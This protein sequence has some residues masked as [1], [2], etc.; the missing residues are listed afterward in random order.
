M[1]FSETISHLAGRILV[2][3]S[4]RMRG[5]S[6]RMPTKLHGLKAKR[7]VNEAPQKRR[8]TWSERGSATS[9]KNVSR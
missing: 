8:G 2:P 6:A 9:K 3:A 5:C 7:P 1:P 4:V